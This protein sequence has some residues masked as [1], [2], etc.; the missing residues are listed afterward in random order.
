MVK[1]NKKNCLIIF[2]F[3]VFN[4]LTAH[5]EIIYSSGLNISV[6]KET[7]K[8]D[9][10]YI[11]AELI[12][13]DSTED[14]VVK[15]KYSE[16]DSMK[17]YFVSSINNYSE[18][19]L[20]HN[21]INDFPDE[22]KE[23]NL[24]KFPE[25]TQIHFYCVIVDS[26]SPN[27]TY[28]WKKTYTGQN[29]EGVDAL[30]SERSVRPY[31]RRFAAVGRVNENTLAVGFAGWIAVGFMNGIFDITNVFLGGIEKFKIPSLSFLPI[32]SLF[33]DSIPVSFNVEDE[34]LRYVLRREYTDQRDTTYDTTSAL[35]YPGSSLEYYYTLDGTDPKN[36]PTRVHYTAPF[37]ISS[38][39]TVK[40]YA[41]V[42]GNPD[43]YPSEVI[44]RTYTKSGTVATKRNAAVPVAFNSFQTGNNATLFDIS[45]RRISTNSL[46]AKQGIQLR[47]VGNTIT[48][49]VV[50]R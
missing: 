37:P 28:L 38:T 49:Q 45:G 10:I 30:V 29:R 9:T 17:I 16:G 5:A 21:H 32:D 20:F 36:S 44:T 15:W 3:F 50:L 39:T 33:N 31:D 19:F 2:V 26:S 40:A 22:K 13:S 18:Q 42:E 43:W 25:G 35:D 23:H 24:G 48:R 14:V 47:K 41:V 12:V 1:L 8:V 46:A 6:F 11:G 27:L 4:C 34:A 7:F